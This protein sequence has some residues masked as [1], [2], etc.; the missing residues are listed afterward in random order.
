MKPGQKEWSKYKSASEWRKYDLSAY[1]SAQKRGLLDSVCEH[2]GWD[3]NTLTPIGYW[4]LDKC[5][6][7]ALNYK[8]KSEWSL[9]KNSGFNVAQNNGWLEECCAH[10]KCN[11]KWT[12]EL[13]KED[14][15]NF[16][17]RKDW[18]KNGKGYCAAQRKGWLEDCCTHMSIPKKHTKW[19]LESTKEDALKYKTRIDWRKAKDSA[20]YSSLKN[21]FYKECIKHMI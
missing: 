9:S 10:M 16:L 17:Y 15:L 1:T 7:N 20:Y 18:Q 14:A 2:F 8:S 5:K 21:G 3:K 11:K 12:K 19:T 6:E 4:T 13:C